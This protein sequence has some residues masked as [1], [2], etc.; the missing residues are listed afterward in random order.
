MKLNKT[1]VLILLP[2]VLALAGCK[3]ELIDN[4][5]T[6]TAVIAKQ[7]QPLDDS[8]KQFQLGDTVV[9]MFQVSSPNGISKIEF[10]NY[11]GVGENRKAPVVLSKVENL[12]G[13]TWTLADTIKGIQ[14]DI[15]FSVYV[16]DLN[17]QYQTKQINAYLD[18]TRYLAETLYDGLANGTSKTFVNVES[19]RTFFIANTIG[20]PAGIDF[21]F[22]YLESQSQVLACLV[23]FDAYWY[24]GNYSM[25]ANSLNPSVTFKKSI[26]ATITSTTWIKD[27]VKKASDLK[28]FYDA[29]TAY[30]TVLP[31]FPDEKVALN[32]KARDVIAFKTADGRYG[33]IQVTA[34]DAKSGTAAN[35]QKISFAMVVDKKMTTNN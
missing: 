23:S 7:G 9:Y 5:I 28:T 25:V 33:L 18:V 11:E 1:I 13:T 20:D 21:G 10:S 15:R 4:P 26:A 32:I 3:K 16:E 12:S 6:I 34:V 31:L 19:G 30:P 24:T 35:T 29:A 22:A 8:Q 17:R 14:N 2:A 27:K